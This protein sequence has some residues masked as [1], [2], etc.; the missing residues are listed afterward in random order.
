MKIGFNFLTEKT[1]HRTTKWDKVGVGMSTRPWERPVPNKSSSE[2]PLLS[3]RCEL[4]LAH[5]IRL[6][7]SLQGRGPHRR[8]VDRLGPPDTS[9][10]S[11]P[12]FKSHWSK[13]ILLLRIQPEEMKRL[14]GPVE[15]RRASGQ[16]F[17]ESFARNPPHGGVCDKGPESGGAWPLWAL[18]S[19][20]PSVPWGC[21]CR[22]PNLLLRVLPTWCFTDDL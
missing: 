2:L 1:I 8:S 6:A 14:H 9:C 22:D 3:P 16:G 12:S 20:Q 17:P 10:R 19:H 15:E 18:S 13:L 7:D 21:P 4:F 11:V 5:S